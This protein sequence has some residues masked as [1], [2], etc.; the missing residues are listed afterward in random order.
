MHSD[1][2][3]WCRSAY[4]Q[5][6]N[7]SIEKNNSITLPQSISAG[8]SNFPF[9]HNSCNKIKHKMRERKKP[10]KK[11]KWRK[12]SLLR[13]KCFFILIIIFQIH[14]HT[15]W[16]DL[17]LREAFFFFFFFQIF[18]IIAKLLFVHSDF[19]GI[20]CAAILETLAIDNSLKCCSTS[21]I[22]NWTLGKKQCSQFARRK[23]IEKLSLS[24]HRFMNMFAACCI[25]LLE[26]TNEWA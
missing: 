25:P 21:R 4:W 1:N 7:I 17:Y 20:K 12:Y 6:Q 11:S 13:S 5:M 16:I 24:F 9:A 10:Q 22:Y 26:W 8:N 14:M 19:H 3:L 18:Q 23:V 2:Q 15:I